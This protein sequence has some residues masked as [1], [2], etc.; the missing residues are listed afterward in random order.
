M[1]NIKKNPATI[2]ELENGDFLATPVSYNKIS[3]ALRKKKKAR[4]LGL[5]AAYFHPESTTTINFKLDEMCRKTINISKI[6]KVEESKPNYVT[7]VDDLE[8]D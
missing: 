7:I 3:E 8:D 5:Y 2:I 4:F 1:K 6:V